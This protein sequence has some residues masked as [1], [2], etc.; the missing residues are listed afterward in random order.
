MLADESND[1]SYGRA[2]DTTNKSSNDC[3]AH[4]KDWIWALVGY[5]IGYIITGC[6]IMWWC[7]K[8]PNEKS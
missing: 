6:V 5:A 1:A 7:V 8:Q 4:N 2:N 3:I